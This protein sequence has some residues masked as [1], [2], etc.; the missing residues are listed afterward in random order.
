MALG[1]FPIVDQTSVAPDTVMYLDT[2]SQ[3]LG[4]DVTQ[5]P[6]ISYYVPQDTVAPHGEALFTGALPNNTQQG[7][8]V[9]PLDSLRLDWTEVAVTA[10]TGNVAVYLYKANGWNKVG[11][12]NFVVGASIVLK[13]GISNAAGYYAVGVNMNT[14]TGTALGISLVVHGGP[15]DEVWA[16]RASAGVRSI[17]PAIGA[18]RV[19]AKSLRLSNGAPMLD[20]QGYMTAWQSTGDT[21]WQD[22]AYADN[23]YNEITSKDNSM[24]PVSNA[25]GF[26]GFMQPVSGSDFELAE[27]T[28][29]SNGVNV[30]TN[31]DLSD[32]K[33]YL[34]AC[35]T[36]ADPTNQSLTLES[37]EVIEYR[38]TSKWLNTS[39]S[40]NRIENTN[41]ALDAVKNL[42]AFYENPSH[43]KEIGKS[44]WNFLK[45][46]PGYVVKYGPR[47]I[48]EASLL[49]SAL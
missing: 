40:G 27:L 4:G 5:F 22:L 26:Y 49:A 11:D 31:F 46:V 41:A 42:P 7:V 23:T 38:T 12:Y 30:Q 39:V 1:R 14:F 45:K 3:L 21:D 29:V 44:I 34:V 2:H 17:L 18:N 24:Q 16:H 6:E 33:N 15:N 20:K 25:K 9:G 35:F 47:V 8:Y 48:E 13:N 10:M 28:L 37:A 19:L 36:V 32:N 43:I